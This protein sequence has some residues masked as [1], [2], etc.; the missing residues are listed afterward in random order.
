MDYKN[1]K[2]SSKKTV[3]FK[4]CAPF[5]NF[6]NEI[7]NTEVDYALNIIAVMPVYN[8]IEYSDVYSK[9]SILY[10]KKPALENNSNIILLIIVF[11]SLLFKFKTEKIWKR[12]HKRC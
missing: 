1:A 3:I 2:H 9:T 7:N 8:L 12:R 10:R 11:N 5:I 6:I 4:N